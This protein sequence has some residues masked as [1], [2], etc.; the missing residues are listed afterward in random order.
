MTPEQKEARRPLLTQRIKLQHP[1]RREWP[2]MSHKSIQNSVCFA[3][4]RKEPTLDELDDRA[5]LLD[6]VGR[7]MLAGVA[8]IGVVIAW[9]NI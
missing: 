2:R 4:F 9:G 7:V 5:A 8:L 6:G 3:M 1:S